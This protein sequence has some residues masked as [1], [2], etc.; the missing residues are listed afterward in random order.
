MKVKVIKSIDP[1]N[2][3][4]I[5]YRL[6]PF[7]SYKV[8]LDELAE[9]MSRSSSINKSDIT[10]VIGAL[11]PEFIGHLLKGGI[12]EV[13]EIGSFRL[14]ISSKGRD[15]PDETSIEDIRGWKIIFRPDIRLKKELSRIKF[16]KI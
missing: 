14:S 13:E 3:S 10:G 15:K 16:E 8:G 7:Y 2:P 4:E 12:V 11:I 6:T 9:E 5:K 1:R